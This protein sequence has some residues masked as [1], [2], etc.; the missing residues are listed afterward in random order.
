MISLKRKK[1]VDDD[2]AASRSP[3]G[4]TIDGDF[5]KNPPILQFDTI[6][7]DEEDDDFQDDKENAV[8]NR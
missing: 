7:V 3:T 2:D 1:D 4:S 5:D 6:E 8:P